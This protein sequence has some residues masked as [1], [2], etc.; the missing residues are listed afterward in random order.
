MKKRLLSTLLLLILCLF[1]TV[2]PVYSQQPASEQYKITD[3]GF[4]AGGTDGSSSEHY[5]VFGDLGEVDTGSSASTLYNIGSGLEFTMMANTPPAP[6]FEN[7]NN[8]YNKLHIT[9]NQGNNPSDTTYAIMIS[10]DVFQS[11][12]QYIQVDQTTGAT[13]GT[14][15]WQTYT[16]WG[17]AS[18][19]DVIGL[20]PNT[21]YTIRVAA[22]QGDFTQSRWS[23][24][25][26]ATTSTITLSFDIDIASADEESEPPYEVN[27]D[28][29]SLGSVTTS[30]D[31][32]WIDL[33]TNAEAGG[34]VYIYGTNEGLSSA[35]TAYTI[36]S[37]TG[38]LS[39]VNEGYGIRTNSASQTSG[40]PLVAQSPY[41]GAG[42]NVGIV[43]STIRTLYS[44]SNTPI[45]S[46]RG[47]FEIQIKTR[48]TTPSSND[49]AEILTIIS[50]A[51]F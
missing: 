39:A 42:N 38:D 15:D 22:K 10:S 7:Q 3:Y 43:D 30:E 4:G 21:E 41:D 25:A 12:I 37:L 51:I 40:G 26:I 18:G 2:Y 16:A 32:V 33:D 13:L 24:T 44:S 49:Y 45:V 46:G 34:Y 14:E 9:I 1:S 27:I 5:K 50:S 20:L 17:G 31:K 23:P 11:D 6:T 47:S 48:N 28:N 36:S 35:T 29:V 19:F 8:N